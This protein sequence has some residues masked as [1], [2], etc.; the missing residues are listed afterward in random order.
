MPL[1][2]DVPYCVNHPTTRLRPDREIGDRM[3]LSSLRLW[4]SARSD[5]MPLNMYVCPKCG[6]VEMYATGIELEKDV[7]Q[8]ERPLSFRAFMGSSVLSALDFDAAVLAAMQSGAPPFNGTTVTSDV[9]LESGDRTYAIDAVVER[10]KKLYVV[11]VK[12]AVSESIIHETVHEAMDRAAMYS[13]SPHAAGRRAKPIVIVPDGA[14]AKRRIHGVPIIRFDQ[15][16]GRFVGR[17]SDSP[18]AG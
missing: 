5:N 16:V 9:Q 18:G 17:L 11:E 13:G 14:Q 10:H 6:Y 8:V 15:N 4:W 2:H 12:A 7:E 3:K 1:K